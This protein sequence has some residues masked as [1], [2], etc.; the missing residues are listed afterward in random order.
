M[1]RF[2][3]AALFVAA[4]ILPAWAQSQAVGTTYFVHQE[5]IAPLRGTLQSGGR[6]FLVEPAQLIA[7]AG[8]REVLANANGSR[9]VVLR[10][11][12]RPTPASVVANG[13]RNPNPSPGEASIIVWNAYTRKANTVWRQ[14][15]APGDHF[16]SRMT[17]TM[18]GPQGDRVLVW[19]SLRKAQ[20]KEPSPNLILLIDTEKSVARQVSVPLDVY[21]YP[22]ASPSVPFAALYGPDGATDENLRFLRPDG[23]ITNPITFTGTIFWQGWHKN[24]TVLRGVREGKTSEW[25]EANPQTGV[26][27]AIATPPKEEQEVD[28]RV[29]RPAPDT[30][31]ELMLSSRPPLPKSGTQ[32]PSVWLQAQ[33]QTP[34]KELV[35]LCAEGRPVFL[36]PRAALFLSADGALLAAPVQSVSET[37]LA[38]IRRKLTRDTDLRDVSRLANVL[39]SYASKNDKTLPPS[40]ANLLGA[41]APYLEDP[42]IVRGFSYTPPPQLVSFP[43][44]KNGGTLAIG[45]RAGD[46]GKTVL[47]AD[48]HAAWQDDP[49]QK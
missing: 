6:G 17:S 43:N 37:V 29:K 9:V 2:L 49:P 14:R 21:T 11:T 7:D 20:I 44:F 48:G 32:T 30:I 19:V 46:G 13:N 34:P 47:Y 28:N 42:S 40:G 41:L 22:N 23:S 39:Y 5:D 10:E 24:G 18:H 1:K 3:F 36:L 8:V 31:P 25:F 38:D 27:T 16:G 35:L 33:G 45:Y 12:Y 26:L 4:P 15:I